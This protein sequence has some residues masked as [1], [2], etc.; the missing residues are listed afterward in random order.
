MRKG[1]H[2]CGSTTGVCG[3]KLSRGQEPKPPALVG[4]QPHL[5]RPSVAVQTAGRVVLILISSADRLWFVMAPRANPTR[6]PEGRP[7]TPHLPAGGPRPRRASR[8][9][10]G[11]AARRGARIRAESL[12]RAP[13]P[14]PAGWQC[15]RPA[16]HAS[17]APPHRPPRLLRDR[18]YRP[19]KSRFAS[20][21]PVSCASDAP[22][23]AASGR[24][25]PRLAHASV[26]GPRLK[27]PVPN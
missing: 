20:P 15:P 21:G 19:G 11:P 4:D 12:C 14:R 2:C 9:K 26:I 25:R 10:A 1:P 6:S 7:G 5:F 8:Q 18:H 3:G 22:V 17:T 13:N 27:L 24:H 23:K 16:G